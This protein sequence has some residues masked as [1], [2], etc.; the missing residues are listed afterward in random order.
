MKRRRYRIF[1]IQLKCFGI[2][3]APPKK[4]LGFK[5][6][7]N[8]RIFECPSFQG[9]LY[10]A[11]AEEATVAVPVTLEAAQA[12]PETVI[13]APVHEG[14]PVVADGTLPKR[15]LLVEGNTP[16]IERQLVLPLLIS[17]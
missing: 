7:K 11:E 8:Q 17:K 10:V 1:P 16:S 13:R 2:K 6:S 5:G 9:L 12:E 4:G 3:K 14:N 15:F